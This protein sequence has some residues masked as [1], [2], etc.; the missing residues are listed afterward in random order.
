M[1]VK[2]LASVI[3][4]FILFGCSKEEIVPERFYPRNDHEAYWYSLKK[5][6]LLNTALGK[7]WLK[8]AKRPFQEQIEVNLPYQESFFISDKIPDA[9]GYRFD[10]KRGQEVLID[11]E[12]ISDD[13]TEV[14]VDLFR[15]ENDSL[16]EFLQ[17]A[18]ADSTLDLSFQPRKDASYLLRLQ[19]ELLRGGKF[20]ITIEKVP[21]LA[22]PVA[23]KNKT[24]IGSFF[25][26]PRDG[27]R[28]EHHGV[29]IFAKR[30][31]PILAP[32]KGEIRFV[33]TRGIGGKVVW[34]H[35][36]NTGNNLYFA[37][38]QDQKVKRYQKV[39]RGDTLGTVGNSGNARTTPPH[40]HFGIYN[41]G[42]VDPYA[43]L[44]PEYDGPAF[45]A[46][47]TVMLGA[48]FI[49][50]KKLFLKD[51]M[52]D[53]TLHL[54]TLS[55]GDQVSITAINHD[56]IRILTASGTKGFI[57]KRDIERF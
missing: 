44:I 35:D 14:F 19:P 16:N 37:H 5:A 2:F 1:P 52:T 15:V 50:P 55:A 7:E 43:F 49:L 33:G 56:Y 23:G 17:V 27:G 26:D 53:P 48:D 45:S 24:A 18:S 41:N 29:D 4:V 34:L 6:D 51:G 57:R 22:F 42:P 47:D 36:Y 28:R 13:T 30:H 25:G 21:S 20:T 3:L 39:T 31:T 46:P 8:A 40:L 9:H 11:I 38:L 10:V 54:D 32:T 12:L